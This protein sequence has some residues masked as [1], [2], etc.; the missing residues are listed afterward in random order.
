M[1]HDK[2][3]QI[4]CEYYGTDKAT[5]LSRTRK[6]EIMEQRQMLQLFLRLYYTLE[7]VGELTGYNH[8]TII[9]NVKRINNYIETEQRVRTDYENIRQIIV[10]MNRKVQTLWDLVECWSDRVEKLRNEILYGGHSGIIQDDYCKLLNEMERRFIDIK[11]W[12]KK[13]LLK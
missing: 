5:I 2:I 3:L 1:T 12:G 11:F 13:L 6:A 7:T 10:L 8:A 9:S 4:V